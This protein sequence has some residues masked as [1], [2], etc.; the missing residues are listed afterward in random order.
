MN[1]PTALDTARI[2][3]IFRSA[4]LCRILACLALTPDTAESR[5]EDLVTAARVSR[6]SVLDALT[7]LEDAHLVSPRR[8]GRRILYRFESAHPLSPA[9]IALFEATVMFE[10]PAITTRKPGPAP[11]SALR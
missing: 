6:P 10:S 5:I 4:T 9:L 3:T 2:E 7:T 1:A 8:D 11:R